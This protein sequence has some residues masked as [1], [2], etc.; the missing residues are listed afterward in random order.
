VDTSCSGR[1]YG[2]MIEEKCPNKFHSE[3]EELCYDN[4]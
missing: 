1:A 2:A 4:G 3:A